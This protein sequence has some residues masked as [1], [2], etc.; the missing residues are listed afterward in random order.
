M[1]EY[2]KPELLIESLVEAENI[3]AVTYESDDDAPTV[4]IV[5]GWGDDYW[6]SQA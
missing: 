5:Y 2:I 3:A 1:K 4:S 6:D